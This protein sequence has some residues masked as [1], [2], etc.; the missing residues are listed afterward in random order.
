MDILP[1]SAEIHVII[2]LGMFIKTNAAMHAEKVLAAVGE[3]AAEH[4][5]P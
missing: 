3:A 4:A 2:K 1:A 5:A